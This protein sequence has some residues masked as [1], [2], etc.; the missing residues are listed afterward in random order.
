MNIEN[1][2]GFKSYNTLDKVKKLFDDKNYQGNNNIYILM[3]KDPRKHNGLVGGME[4]PYMA[5]L[6]N[7]SDAGIGYFYLNFTKLLTVKKGYDNLNIYLDSYNFIPNDSI[8]SVE[9]KKFIFNKK[10]IQLIIKTKD[11]KVHYLF[12]NLE[13]DA[14]PYYNENMLKLIEKYSKK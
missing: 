6:L 4:Y 3:N 13:N 7:I 11:K 14:I 1:N 2:L 5:L 10:K 12:D 9:V 8:L